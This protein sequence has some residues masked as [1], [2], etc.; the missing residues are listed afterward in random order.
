[1]V[2]LIKNQIIKHLSIFAKNLKPEQISLEVLG[3]TGELRNIV[4]NEEVLSEKL[5]LPPFLRIRRAE[6]NRVKVKVPWTKLNSAPVEIIV[7]ELHVTLELGTHSSADPPRKSSSPNSYGFADRVVEG[8]SIKINVLDISFESASFSGSL[9]LSPLTVESVSPAW[10]FVSSLKKTRISDSSCHQVIF[11]KQI[12]WNL[13]KIQ[14]FAHSEGGS[15]RGQRLNSPLRL[16]TQ[17]GRCRIAIKKDSNDGSLLAGR[18]QT[19]FEDI[20]WVA[21]LAEVRSAISFYKHI[22]ALAK[23][24]GQTAP[25]ENP[26]LVD[27]SAKSRSQRTSLP[28]PAIKSTIFKQFDVGQTSH[29]VYINKVH[30]TLIDDH[31]NT[32]DYPA[33]WNITSGAMQVTLERISVDFY[34]QNLISDDRRYWVRY[35]TPNE[36][37]V[38]AANELERHLLNL[39]VGLDPTARE[40]LNRLWSTLTSQSLVI[41]IEDVVVECVSEQTTKREDLQDLYTSKTSTRFSI[42]THVPAIHFE[43]SN[44]FFPGST[45]PEPPVGLAH[46]VIGPSVVLVDTR[47]IRWMLYVID[48]ITRSLDIEENAGDPPVVCA[49]IDLLMPRIVIP[50]S[51]P[52]EDERYP[53]KFVVNVSTVT[54]SNRALDRE[55]FSIENLFQSLTDD[56]LQ[57]ISSVENEGK[58]DLRNHILQT[59]QLAAELA[60]T[61]ASTDLLPTRWYVAT[62]P[63]WVEAVPPVPN[64]TAKVYSGVTV[65]SDVMLAGCIDIK[66]PNLYIALE[67]LNSLGVVI[68]HFQFIQ[69]M[70]VQ[71]SIS[72]MVEQIEIDKKFFSSISGVPVSD[73]PLSLYCFCE[74]I[75]VHLVLPVGLAPSP[76]ETVSMI[77]KSDT[78]TTLSSGLS[79]YFNK[80]T[81][82][83]VYKPEITIITNRV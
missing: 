36:F 65:L 6:C 1:M 48:N 25:S 28:N 77:S 52:P 39:S 2:S 3:G 44:Y 47:T 57:F 43:F 22:V 55:T 7:D 17:G 27:Y 10:S 58:H 42:P 53:Q 78:D 67:P 46:G 81:K 54:V 29:H 26:F 83:P 61:G 24:S 71:K 64:T 13:L 62:S 21:T 35:E 19:I 32:K 37:T 56:N 8:L 45:Q 20:H 15:D 70:R 59:K 31:A 23:A 75:N 63:L 60:T 76:F 73:S 50:C 51:T 41:R 33:N 30:M 72:D 11:F 38:F 66:L 74:E 16:I 12:T 40:R 49:R 14:A 9:W 4:L 68:D 18:I 34:L 5:E 79:V 69:L 80:T 82:R